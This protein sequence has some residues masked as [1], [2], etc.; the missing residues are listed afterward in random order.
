M[1]ISVWVLAISLYGKGYVGNIDN[2]ATKE[3]C[4]RLKQSLTQMSNRS[5]T[6]EQSI[7]IEVKK[8][9]K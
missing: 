2:I 4:E 1:I 8:V 3:E 6:Y 5:T 7:C 9:M